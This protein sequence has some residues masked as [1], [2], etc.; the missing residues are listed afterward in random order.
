MSQT[1]NEYLSKRSANYL[2]TLLRFPEHQSSSRFRQSRFE[3]RRQ[4]VFMI[5]IVVEGRSGNLKEFCA[6]LKFYQHFC[7]CSEHLMSASDREKL[8]TIDLLLP[9][10]SAYTSSDFS[11]QY[12]CQL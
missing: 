12:H 8:T 2:I 10:S 7:T 11:V 1:P 5:L 9:V 3:E 6:F 4:L